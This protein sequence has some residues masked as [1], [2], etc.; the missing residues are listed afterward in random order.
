MATFLLQRFLCK[1]H[2]CNDEKRADKSKI[3][4]CSVVHRLIEECLDCLQDTSLDFE[5]GE[6][7]GLNI[8]K[9]QHALYPTDC[10]QIFTQPW[11]MKDLLSMG[12]SG[13]PTVL[14]IFT[15]QLRQM[16]RVRFFQLP[17][18][19]PCSVSTLR[20]A[21]QLQMGRGLKDSPEMYTCHQM[22]FIKIFSNKHTNIVTKQRETISCS[23]TCPCWSPM[24]ISPSDQQAIG[25]QLALC[26][27]LL[28]QPLML[29]L[30]SRWHR[31][32]QPHKMVIDP[33]LL[34]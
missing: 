9:L 28:K 32:C 13:C 22:Y 21:L 30:Q 4:F 27:L 7:A 26:R 34:T 8:L 19:I 3:F 12:K 18:I 14:P 33:C 6:H 11:Q 29:L 24:Q 23:S 16:L 20:S 1:T 5:S 2:A 25:D 31:N 17:A 15:C 10:K